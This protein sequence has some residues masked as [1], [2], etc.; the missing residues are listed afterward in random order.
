MAV[1][2]YREQLTAPASWWIGAVIFGTV[3]G[4]VVAV[5]TTATAGIIGGLVGTAVAGAMVA[6]YGHVVVA[7]GPDGLHVGRAHLTPEY[8]GDVTVLDGPGMR[9]LL[10][11]AADAR[12]WMR[13]RSYVPGGLRVDV[14]DP[15]DPV[16]Y[17]LIS[18]RKPAAVAAALAHGTD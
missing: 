9:H 18:C 14:D 5:A 12:A 3:V 6:A 2:T 8:L 17:W 10:G 11:P 7:A 16:P 4:W 13:T 15:H 1:A